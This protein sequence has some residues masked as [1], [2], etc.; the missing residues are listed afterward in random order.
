MKGLVARVGFEDRFILCA[1]PQHHQLLPRV[2]N[3]ALVLL[4]ELALRNLLG[5]TKSGRQTDIPTTFSPANP[6]L[7]VSLA[8]ED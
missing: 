5:K 1:H 7:Y 6:L 3:R 8:L 2:Q 4:E